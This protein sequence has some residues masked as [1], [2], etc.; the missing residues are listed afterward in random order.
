MAAVNSNILD[1]QFWLQV[2][3]NN[4]RFI[5]FALAYMET[6]EIEKAEG[7]I[8]RFI[9]LLTKARENLADDQII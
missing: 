8:R 3:G 2:V 6:N 7:F 5:H 9:S 4:A 1:N